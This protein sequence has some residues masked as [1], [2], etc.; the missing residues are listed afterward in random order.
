MIDDVTYILCLLAIHVP[1][2]KCLF[3]SCTHFLNCF[4]KVIELFKFFIYCYISRIFL[5]L[6]DRSIIFF[7]FYS[8]LLLFIFSVLSFEEQQVLYFDVAQSTD[9]HGWYFFQCS[10]KCHNLRFAN[11]F[12]PVSFGRFMVL[13]FPFRALI[14]FGLISFFYFGL[15][16]VNNVR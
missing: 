11:D 10:K 15:I 14:H 8:L 1:S 9:V 13:S 4:W 16:F 12:L 3:R 6:S 7:P 2:L 5:C